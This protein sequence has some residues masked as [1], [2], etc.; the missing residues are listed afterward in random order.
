M[1]STGTGSPVSTGAPG[2][3]TGTGCGTCDHIV[4]GTRASANN[5]TPAIIRRRC[6]LSWFLIS[7]LRS[8]NAGDN[9]GYLQLDLN[10]TSCKDVHS[11]VK[12]HPPRH[13]A[14]FN[15]MVT[16]LK[17]EILELSDP[18]QKAAIDINGAVFQVGLDL[19]LSGTR[20]G[21]DHPGGVVVIGVIIRTVD[22]TPS[23][24]I[25]IRPDHN[26]LCRADLRQ[27]NDS[28]HKA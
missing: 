10:R 28:H 16:G 20:C 3:G 25:P 15:V 13:I 4:D 5:A 27:C 19:Y 14:Y 18:A 17:R 21:N 12:Q 2:T 9:R 24:V 23:R 26:P 8:A 6:V 7:I 11:I 1:D 22:R